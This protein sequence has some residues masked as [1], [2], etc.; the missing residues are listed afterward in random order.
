LSVT[1]TV[2]EQVAVFPL[3]SVAVN[4]TGVTPMGNEDPEGNPLV[5]VSINP[6]QL[7]LATGAAHNTTALHDPGV[8]L[9]EILAGQEVNTGTW[10]SVTVTVKEHVETFPPA[11]V[12]ANET[13]V[14]PIGKADPDGNP[15]VCVNVIPGQLS[16]AAGATHVTM[17]EQLPGV[18]F[19]EMFAGHELNTGNWLSVTVTV[20]VHTDEFP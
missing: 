9:T 1:V 12:A 17:A 15:A 2:N 16:L 20:K 8:L 7:S 3:A 6:G 18:L 10:L 4:E 14:T 13:F 11:S 19:T 5:C